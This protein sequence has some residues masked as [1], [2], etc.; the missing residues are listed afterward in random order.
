MAKRRIFNYLSTY[1]T[2]TPTENDKAFSKT[3]KSVVLRLPEVTGYVDAK[4]PELNVPKG[5]R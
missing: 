5:N 4:H 3:L 1:P 2:R